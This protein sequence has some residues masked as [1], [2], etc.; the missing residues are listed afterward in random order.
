MRGSSLWRPF[1]SSK[2]SHSDVA[3]YYPRALVHCKVL[4][5]RRTGHRP[6]VMD[7]GA[8]GIHSPR[9]AP[10]ECRSHRYHC[11]LFAGLTKFLSDVPVDREVNRY[12]MHVLRPCRTGS[13]LF[14]TP[15]LL[16]WTQGS[17]LGVL[18]ESA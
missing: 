8:T 15:R 6:R 16:G 11:D 9:M 10:D 7:Y 1:I 3:G 18:S 13:D 2:F 4:D 12:D 5:E 14:T 17:N